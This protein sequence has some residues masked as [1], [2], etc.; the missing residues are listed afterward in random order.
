MN[1]TRKIFPELL[2]NQFNQNEYFGEKQKP[3]TEV[4]NNFP[5]PYNKLVLKYLDFRNEHY[6]VKSKR[7][8]LELAFWWD[9]TSEDVGFWIRLADALEG[10]GD[11]PEISIELIDGPAKGFRK[12]KNL[13]RLVRIDYME[14]IDDLNYSYKITNYE[15]CMKNGMIAYRH[16]SSK[17]AEQQQLRE[18]ANKIRTMM[19]EARYQGQYVPPEG[20]EIRSR[21]YAMMLT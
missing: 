21:N 15:Q 13:D 1:I 12:F 7:E 17:Y 20:I 18:E 11:F 5:N 4:I 16:V 3:I 14:K 2:A 19:D 6:N 10:K 8:A 9:E